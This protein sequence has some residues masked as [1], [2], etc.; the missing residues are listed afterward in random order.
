MPE[1]DKPAPG[2]PGGMAYDSAIIAEEGVAF[3]YS[4]QRYK[5][6]KKE[7]VEGALTRLFYEMPEGVSTH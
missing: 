6:F 1:K 7:V 2:G 4:A 3:D 5:L